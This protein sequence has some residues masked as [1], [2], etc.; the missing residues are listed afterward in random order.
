MDYLIC[1]HVILDS[2]L[3][4]QTLVSLNSWYWLR[5]STQGMQTYN[6]NMN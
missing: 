4:G 5:P 1:C 6:Q 2:M 3:V